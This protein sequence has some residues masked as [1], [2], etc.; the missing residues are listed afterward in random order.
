MTDTQIV[1]KLVELAPELDIF[2]IEDEKEGGKTSKIIHVSNSRTR[3]RC[4]YCG[5]YSRNIHSKL[6]PV[7]IK[8]LD[9]AGYTTYL[10]VYKRRF[11]CKN[12]G[13]IFTEDNYIN[14]TKKSIS[15]KLEQKILMDLRDYN[16]SIKYIGERNNVSDNT[17]RNI[18]KRYMRN[19]P[20]HLRLL[21]SINII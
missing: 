17:V 4:V 14:G 15:L 18:L 13:K 20:E 21:P 7:K 16:L 12:C 2:E 5:K 9:I 1:S 3:V 19:Y 6:K 10:K 11:I 8:Y